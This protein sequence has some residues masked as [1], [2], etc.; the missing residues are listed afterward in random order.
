[1]NIADKFIVEIGQL[2]LRCED[3]L[4]NEWDSVSIVYDVREGHT[5]NSGF[6]YTKDRVLPICASIDGEP[7]LFRDKVLGLREKVQHETGCGFVQLLIQMEKVTGRIKIDC[8]F[9]D[10]KRWAIK[11]A[12]IKVMRERL[13]PD[14]S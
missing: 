3:M 14:F 5:A 8:E 2:I 10:P 1:M 13:R 7:L 4:E 12:E 6:L 9:D 11:P